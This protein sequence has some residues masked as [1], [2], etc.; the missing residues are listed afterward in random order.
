MALIILILLT[1]LGMVAAFTIGYYRVIE[2]KPIPSSKNL[3]ISIVVCFRNEAPN[4]AQ[5]VA[6][7]KKLN[8][9]KEDFEVIAVNDHSCDK[10]LLLLQKAQ[11]EFPNLKILSLDN[12]ELGK[13]A[14]LHSGVHAAQGTIIAVTDADCRLPKEWLKQIS[15]LMSNHVDLVCGP[16]TYSPTTFFENVAAIEFGGLVAS[17]IGAAGIG[18]PMYCNG[19]NMAFR[20][21]LYLAA[22]LHTNSTPSGDDVFLLHYAKQNGRN[23]YFAFG[24]ENC[25]TTAPDKN[26][27]DLI[28]RRIRW[29]SKTPFYT[30]KTSKVVA[31]IVLT[32]NL[33]LLCLGFWCIEDSSLLPRF[34]AL[35]GLKAIIEYG[36]LSVHFKVNNV[37]LW[38]KYFIPTL[39]VYPFYI[40][41]TAL[42]SIRRKFVW[43]ERS[44]K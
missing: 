3:F 16:V 21:E 29:G 41:F 31:F 19:A 39:M 10:T 14:A 36:L 11:E 7:L 1:Y 32:A 22:N 28:H 8:Y 20:K 17:G 33:S 35:Y 6:S 13:K 27:S 40:T 15:N 37:N 26:L 38:R 44:Y 43:K 24:E 34:I 12:V 2:R 25:V 4:I 18:M 9:P 42:A 23:I 30:D 5:L